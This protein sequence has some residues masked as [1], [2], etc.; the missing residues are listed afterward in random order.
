MDDILFNLNS[1]LILK[2]IAACLIGFTI[3]LERE[4]RNK[5]A[6]IKTFA[7]ICLGSTLFTDISMSILAPADPSRVTAQIVSGLGFIGAGTIFQSRHVITG[8]TTAA[9][10]WVIGALGALIGM[11]KYSEAFSCLV[12]IYLYFGLSH[13]IQK[14]VFQKRKFYMEIIVKKKP[15]IAMIEDV[16]NENKVFLKQK[17]WRKKD[18]HYKVECSYFVNPVKNQDI[19][20]KLKNLDFVVGIIN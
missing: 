13:I 18:K 7:L 8:L 11:G 12:I 5:P 2:S 14:L 19:K 1:D 17:S 9:E 16:F 15:H 20:L 10:L 4:F 3:G 6:G